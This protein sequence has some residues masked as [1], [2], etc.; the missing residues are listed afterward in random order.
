LQKQEKA[1]GIDPW[2]YLVG[3]FN[4]N[5][6]GGR[7][8]SL[9]TVALA[10][11]C[12]FKNPE[13]CTA[14]GGRHKL[15]T[16]LSVAENLSEQARLQRARHK[17][18]LTSANYQKPDVKSAEAVQK[19]LFE[20]VN[21][22]SETSNADSEVL[23]A[24]NASDKSPPVPVPPTHHSS[25]YYPTQFQQQPS[26]QLP[27]LVYHQHAAPPMYQSPE[28]MHHPSPGILQQ[29]TAPLYHPSPAVY[30]Y[31]PATVYQQPSAPVMYQHPPTTIYQQ[32]SAQVM[33]QHPPAAVYQHPTAQVMYQ[34]PP[35]T[36]Y[37]QSSFHPSQ[38]VYQ[39]PPATGYQLPSAPIMYQHPPATYQQFPTSNAVN[40][41]H[42]S[43]NAI[44]GDEP[45]A[46]KTTKKRRKVS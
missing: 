31:P 45:P 24:E 15:S 46:T 28:V 26:Y 38:A 8:F 23:S 5:R 40:L 14:H 6:L 7:Q 25:G 36:V 37:Q 13:R 42:P 41:G 1:T 19:A 21:D 43:S 9:Y 2:P 30:Q 17:T 12:G 44:V 29:P 35:A 16:V 22:E 33:Y 11:R 10:K 39:Y 34:N 27:A 20:D 32:P 3:F 18:V 4:N